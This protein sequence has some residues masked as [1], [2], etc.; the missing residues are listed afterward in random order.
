MEQSQF[1]E[2]Q[3]W[4]M[5][6][7]G[8]G[9]PITLHE[10]DLTKPFIYH[11]KYGIFYCSGG[12]HQSAMSLLLAFDNG[13]KDGLTAAEHFNLEH[14]SGTA[15]YWLGNTPGKAFKS[16]VSSKVHCGKKGFLTVIERRFFGD[17]VYLF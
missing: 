2:Q 1:T 6:N 4:K 15:D 9:H 13:L 7:V 12:Y 10:A 16:S 3:W 8:I 14:S 5:C 17:V 11:R